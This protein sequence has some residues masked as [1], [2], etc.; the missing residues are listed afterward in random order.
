[1][2]K[3]DIGGN[4]HQW[5][6]YVGGVETSAESDFNDSY[7]DSATGKVI[8]RQRSDYFEKSEFFFT[9]TER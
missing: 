7:V 6:E 3:A 1:M 8:K 4:S 5:S 9:I 2:V